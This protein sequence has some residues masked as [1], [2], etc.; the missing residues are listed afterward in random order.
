[1]SVQQEK[2]QVQKTV[3]ICGVEYDVDNDGMIRVGNIFFIP[4][5]A[6]IEGGLYKDKWKR[7]DLCD[8]FKIRKNKLFKICYDC[9]QRRATCKQTKCEKKLFYENYY[10]DKGY[11][12]RLCYDEAVMSKDEEPRIF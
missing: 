12:C 5:R 2:S 1:M 3:K 6:P 4:K 11:C 8:E 9:N 7:C 10:T